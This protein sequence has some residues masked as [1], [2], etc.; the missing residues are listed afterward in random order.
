MSSCGSVTY[1]VAKGLT[2]ILKLLVGKSPRHINSTHD[3]VEQVKQLTL[4]PGECLSSYDVSALFTSVPV[5][6]ALGVI[7]D[8]Q[9]NDATLKDRTVLPVKDMILLLE[10]CLKNM[11]FSSHDQSYEQGEGV[12]MESPVSP[13]VAS[14]YMEYFEQKAL[15]TAPH[16]TPGFGTGMWMTHLTSRRKSTSRTSYNTLTVLTL[17]SSLQW[18]TTRRIVPSPS[19]TPLLNQRLM[20]ISLSLCTGN[21]PT[22]TS[23]YNG[24]V[25]TTSLQSLVLSTPSSIGPK[26]CVAILSFSAKKWIISGRHSP[27]VNTLKVD[28]VE[29]RLNRPPGRLL[30]VLTTRAP[31][32]PSPLPMK[33][34]QRVIVIPY[35]QGLCESIKK[36]CGRYGLQT[37]F[38]GSSTI[39]NLLV[40]PKDKDPMVIK[41]GD[42]YW[43]QCGD[44]PVMMNT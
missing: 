19:W 30:M 12:A 36:I 5:D 20:E 35:T 23:T 10:F 41:S 4:E 27:N 2:K 38:K 6:P 31:Q 34:N 17:S 26:Q 3:F 29:K 37:H 11:Y 22:Q 28:K 43:F 25:T 13:I 24:T 39:R 16:P 8:L 21:Q 32:V 40:S 44:S 7:K 1:G 33:S 18:R 14:P 15:S 9:E 42:I